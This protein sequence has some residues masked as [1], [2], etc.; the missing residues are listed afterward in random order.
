[1][2]KLPTRQV[3]L[4][5]HTSP[6]IPDVGK[7]FDKEKFQAALKE[8]NVNSV[9]VFAK[10]HHGYCYYPSTVGTQHPTM[11]QGFDLTGAMVN[12]A[13]EI[14]VDAPIYI[15][16]GWSVLDSETHPE[17]CMRYKDGS[18]QTMNYDLEAAPD[19]PKPNCSWKNLCLSGEYAEHIYA[20]TEEICDRYEKV[21][22][23]FYDIIY[24]ND[25][26]YCPNCLKG[27]K[28]EG[29]DPANI[30]DARKYYKISHLRFMDNCSKRLHKKHPEATVFFNSGGADIY[31]PEYHDGQTHFEMEDLP[32]AWGGYDKMP[33][34]ASVMSRYGKEYLGMTG[35]F[36][37][38]WGG[39][40]EYKNPEALKYEALLMAMYGS[41]CSIGDQMIP[42]GHLDIETYKCIGTAY[43]ALEAIEPW[44]WPA[45]STAKLGVYLSGNESSDEGLHKMLLEGHIDFEVVLPG[46]DLKPFK[47]LILPDGVKVSDEEAI[48]INAFVNAGGAVLFSGTSLVKDGKF[49]LDPGAEYAGN[50]EFR[51]DYLCVGDKLKLPFGNAPFFCYSSAKRAEV[52]DGE[53]LASVFEPWFDRNYG[54]YCSHR[55][56]PYKSEA[57]GYPGAVKKGKVIWLAHPVFELY[58][59]YGAQLFREV[60]L[61]AL[62]LIY[63]PLYSINLPS[64]GRTRLT[65][66]AKEDR[67]VFHAAYATPMQR[68]CITVLEDMPEFKDV[69]VTIKTDKAVKAVR[70]IPSLEEIAF[71]NKNGEL[72]FAIPYVQCHSA[73]EIV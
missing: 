65:Y 52:T 56:T 26:C 25:V 62:R 44:C 70:S 67:Y 30:E 1:M 13:H 22:G 59:E 40:G 36:H 20:L 18:M 34:R 10:C 28:E 60:A 43:K 41:K 14:G 21:D 11:E 6:L 54:T 64:N 3:H 61:K 73:V 63:T 39:F 42:D 37:T 53:V 32:T 4:D 16:A 31:R 19:T 58:K 50:S 9:T 12:A 23:L 46:D 35:K 69:S 45:V 33:P 5:F 7:A 27:M 38:E 29:L 15:T 55:N 47:A 2:R 17:W 72:S 66:Q 24:L 8:G 57:S 48:K 68:G 49:Q 71:E 51:Q